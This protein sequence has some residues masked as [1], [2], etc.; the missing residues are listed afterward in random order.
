M[1]SLQNSYC[2]WVS[3]EVSYITAHTYS[4]W[5]RDQFHKKVWTR[6]ICSKDKARSGWLLALSR[7]IRRCQLL[8][9]FHRLHLKY[10]SLSLYDDDYYHQQNYP[11]TNEMHILLFSIP[12][13][14]YIKTHR[15]TKS[16]CV[17]FE[18]G[19]SYYYTIMPHHHTHIRALSSLI[20]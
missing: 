10:A 16:V 14:K 7:P 12:T 8:S 6:A 17:G 20:V 4:L 18:Y 15:N 3:F 11:F 19:P 5:R 13:W 2:K 1:K 9:L